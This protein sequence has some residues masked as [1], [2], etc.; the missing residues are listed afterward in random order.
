VDDARDEW[1]SHVR[2]GADSPHGDDHRVAADLN[3]EPMPSRAEPTL[4]TGEM[5]D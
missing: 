4:I 1:Q 5:I 2:I 3:G